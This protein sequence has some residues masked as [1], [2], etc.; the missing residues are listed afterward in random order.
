MGDQQ[1]SLVEMCRP[2]RSLASPLA[3]EDYY[4]K[5]PIVLYGATVCDTPMG[6]SQT[7]Q[8]NKK[9]GTNSEMMYDA[10]INLTSA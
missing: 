4:S 2:A 8:G 9:H 10:K 7:A 6:V 5:S 3:M 1:V